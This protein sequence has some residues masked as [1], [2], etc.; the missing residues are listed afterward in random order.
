MVKTKDWPR[1]RPDKNGFGQ[2]RRWIVDLRPHGG[3]KFFSSKDEALDEARIQRIRLQNEGLEGFEF[4]LDQRLDAKIAMAVLA[5]SGLSLTQAAKIAVE[6]HGIRASGTALNDAIAELLK[7]KNKRS[8]RYQKDLRLKLGK[9]AKDFA[10]QK[11][12]EISVKEVK[13]W[14][15][16]LGAAVTINNYRRVLSV[17]FSHAKIEAW[18][19]SNPI[20][21]CGRGRRRY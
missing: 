5:G 18:I 11:L 12:G 8:E 17:L 1:V 14:L 20:E 10:E 9:F 7:A 6:F 21:Y 16:K 19:A 4:T 3:R 13:S 2:P 15:K